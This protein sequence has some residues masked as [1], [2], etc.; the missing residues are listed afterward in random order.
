MLLFS[1]WNCQSWLP[2]H[3]LST[4]WEKRI[5]IPSTSSFLI[6]YWGYWHKNRIFVANEFISHWFPPEIPGFVTSVCVALDV[7][8]RAGVWKWWN[9]EQQSCLQENELGE[10]EGSWTSLSPYYALGICY[11]MVWSE[12]CRLPP[13]R[14]ALPISVLGVT[15]CWS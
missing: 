8:W 12:A 9:L 2:R 5:F 14:Q 3:S 6:C 15:K 11:H 4:N 10:G 7:A 13:A 1:L